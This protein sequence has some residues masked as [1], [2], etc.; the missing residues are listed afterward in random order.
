[1][2]EES[3]ETLDLGAVTRCCR[4]F[5]CLSLSES[6]RCEE[7]QVQVQN[8]FAS[9]FLSTFE[10]DRLW[11]LMWKWHHMSEVRTIAWW[12]DFVAKLKLPRYLPHQETRDYVGQTL[13]H[14]SRPSPL[15]PQQTSTVLYLCAIHQQEQVL[16][17]QK[18]LASISPDLK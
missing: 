17:W 4:N 14:T 3:E 8:M 15:P 7:N 18:T 11:L 6:C 2:C 12:R 5:G 9:R 13:P 1:M 16:F 10:A